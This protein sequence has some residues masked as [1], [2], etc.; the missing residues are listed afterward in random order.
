MS[1]SEL[2]CFLLE[3]CINRKYRTLKENLEYKIVVRFL[4]SVVFSS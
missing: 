2:C 3:L 1:N 4:I